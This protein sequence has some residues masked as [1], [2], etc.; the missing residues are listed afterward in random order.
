MRG[1][2]GKLRPGANADVSVFELCDGHYELRDG[3]NDT[4]VAKRRPL[5]TTD[6]ERRPRL[7]SRTRSRHEAATEAG[8]YLTPLADCLRANRRNRFLL[9]GPP[10]RLPGAV[11]FTGHAG[12]DR[13]TIRGSP[14]L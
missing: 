11:G 2:V 5:G 12:G 14:V 4:I 7:V 8:F 3:D 6:A 10:L 13:L 1:T 9:A